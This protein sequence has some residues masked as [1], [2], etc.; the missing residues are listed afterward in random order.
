[1][2]IHKDSRRDGYFDLCS[3]IGLPGDINVIRLKPNQFCGMHRHQKQTD[4]FWVIEG[5]V[6]FHFDQ[7]VVWVSWDHDQVTYVHPGIWHGYEAGHEGAVILM[8]L[9]RHYDPNDEEKDEQ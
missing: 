7:T 9:D 5:E 4:R 2:R 6:G 3:E 8:Y 1:M